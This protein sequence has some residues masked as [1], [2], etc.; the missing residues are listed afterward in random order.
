[1]GTSGTFRAS[2]T[3]INMTLLMVSFQCTCIIMKVAM[4]LDLERLIP[5][6]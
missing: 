1:M 4:F 6:Q 5:D 2:N 3:A